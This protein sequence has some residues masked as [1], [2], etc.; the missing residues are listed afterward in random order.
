MNFQD[1]MPSFLNDDFKDHYVLLFDPTSMKNAIEKFYYPELIEEP[2][3]L[4]SKFTFHL[5]HVTELNVLGERKSPLKLTDLALLEKSSKMD[6]ISLQETYKSIQ[7]RGYR[8]LGSFP[9]DNVP[10]H[11]KD[12]FVF[13]N[14]KPTNMQVDHW[15]RI[16]NSCQNLYFAQSLR[17]EK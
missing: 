13:I 5:E 1:D 7:L 16:A 11:D 12:A 10:I 17:R 6:K 9:S 8:Y 4:L 3:R 14:T 2:L 15:I